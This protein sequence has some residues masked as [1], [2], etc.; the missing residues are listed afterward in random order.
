ML[1]QK[2]HKHSECYC[3]ISGEL[4][5]RYNCPNLSEDID[6]VCN[7]FSNNDA[8][9]DGSGGSGISDNSCNGSPE[10]KATDSTQLKQSSGLDSEVIFHII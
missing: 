2:Y 9:S 5:N 3:L 10:V 6:I 8:K 1:F 4:T 7:Y